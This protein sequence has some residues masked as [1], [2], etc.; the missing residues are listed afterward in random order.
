MLDPV[1]CGEVAVA[2]YIWLHYVGG[3]VSLL[4]QHGLGTELNRR[5]GK[6]LG[7]MRAWWQH[8]CGA[9][10][11]RRVSVSDAVCLVLGMYLVL[12]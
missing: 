6:L 2:V 11:C 1:V 7:S 5:L 9:D 10:S 3:V 4:Q 8:S 12:A